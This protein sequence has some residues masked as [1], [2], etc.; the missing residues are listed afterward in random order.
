[1]EGCATRVPAQQV[2]S[3]VVCTTARILMFCEI[4]SFAIFSAEFSFAELIL[5]D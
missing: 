4:L 3:R 1:M 2:Y 5:V